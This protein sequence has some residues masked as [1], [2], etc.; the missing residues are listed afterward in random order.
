MTD[1]R[2]RRQ[3]RETLR[4]N[5][6]QLGGLATPEFIAAVVVSARQRARE[7]N[8][9]PEVNDGA[10]FQ[11]HLE[12][13]SILASLGGWEFVKEALEVRGQQAGASS[14]TI[15]EAVE[16]AKACFDCGLVPISEPLP[17]TAPT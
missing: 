15:L 3:D 7:R 12:I 5:L 6:K 8:Q 16:F 13:L 1:S 9:E 2:Q 11:R 4:G 17:T 10:S 14:E